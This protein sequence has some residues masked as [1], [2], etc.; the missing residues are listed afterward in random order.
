MNLLKEATEIYEK[1]SV[2]KHED[3]ATITFEIIKT[4]KTAEVENFLFFC[5][6]SANKIISINS[7][8]GDLAQCAIYV[9]QLARTAI[10]HNARSVI[11]SHN[12]PSGNITPSSDDVAIT[13]KIKQ[14]MG[15]LDIDVLDHVIIG[16]ETSVLSDEIKM[17]GSFSFAT[18]G[19]I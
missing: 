3:I 15:T 1:Q 2:S 8:T 18:N 14:A 4:N 11:L 10:L 16:T 7:T 6:N 5:L 12:H 19:I 13:K 17:T 9:R